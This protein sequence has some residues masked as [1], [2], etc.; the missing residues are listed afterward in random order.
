MFK[1]KLFLKAFSIILLLVSIFA[2]SMYVISLPLINR[3]VGEIE[4]NSAKTILENVYNLVE[5]VSLDLESEEKAL[6]ESRKRELRN[7]VELGISYIGNIENQ[8]KTG[9]LS[10]DDA[11]KNILEN[12]RWF[13]YGNNDYLWISDYN[14][15]LI[16]HPD[17]KLHNTD[18]SKIKDIYGIFIVPPM[19]EGARKHGEVYHYYYWRRLGES[20]PVKKM[21]YATHLKDW[22]WVIG[23]G[24]YIDDI[25]NDLQK[26]KTNEVDNL[27]KQLA[28]IRIAK[29]GY[30]Y[31]FTSDKFLVSHPNKNIDGT[32]VSYLQNPDTKRPILDELKEIADKTDSYLYYRWDKPEH[33]SEYKYYKKSWVRYFKKFDWYIASSVYEDELK[34]GSVNLINS[35]GVIFIVFI[36]LSLI[37][38]LI[39]VNNLIKPI[40]ELSDTAEKVKYGDLTVRSSVKGN[41]ELGMLARSFNGMVD[42][43]QKNIVNL[44]IMVTERTKELETAYNEL[45]QLDAMKSSFLSTVSHELR[46]PLTSVMGFAKIIKKRLND[47]VFPA[48]TQKTEKIEKTV[49]QIGEN[50]D[51]IVF[52]SERL[53]VLINDILDLAKMESGKMEWKMEKLEINPIIDHAVA[54]TMSLFENRNVKLVKVLADDLPTVT[55][56]RDRLIQVVIN[57]ISNAVKFTEAGDVTVK[58]QITDDRRFVKVSVNDTGIGIA[59]T[60]QEVVFD[61]FKQI[62]SD[63]LVKKPKGTGLGLSICKQIVTHHKGDIWVESVPGKGSSFIFTLPIAF[64]PDN[65]AGL[66]ENSDVAM[67]KELN[68]K[69]DDLKTKMATVMSSFENSKRNILV[70]DDE[71]AMRNLIRQ[72]L[73]EKE[74]TVFEA[75][76]G[77]EAIEQ[78]MKCRPGLVILDIKMPGINGFDVAVTLK[79]D[80]ETMG[81]PVIILSIIE[82]KEKGYRIGV[83]KYLTKPLNTND[84]IKE[85]ELLLTRGVAAKKIMVVSEDS[86]VT[87]NITDIFGAQ[88][89]T[90]LSST[91]VDECLDKTKKEKPGMIIIESTFPKRE[92]LIQTVRFTKEL[93]NT[94]FV[95]I[96]K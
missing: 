7:I 45:K 63:T 18:F 78:I 37:L 57:L 66:S 87:A 58:S 76:N 11:R 10:R 38:G 61:K 4:E 55:A 60:D 82:D 28:K 25:E 16:S 84:L 74:Y 48:I 79:K 24:V 93:D 13:K 26:K 3:K 89:Y 23:T 1:S 68:I 20:K 30:I 53:T 91:T 64:Q 51:I 8:V 65:I 70:V 80:P 96:T 86:E 88:G 56:D 15:V 35:I 39:F 47:I 77:E 12:M 81:I 59:K 31:I 49:R 19:V 50:V 9:K 22:N 44:D 94:Y 14:S 85:V 6:M 34:Q 42:N 52:E 75:S 71:A 67:K 92:N 72:M 5:K 83:D 2:Y 17:P 41:D 21:S 90:V 27:R 54:A 40:R 32:N 62:S 46:T 29:T 95:I 33:P 73:E 36:A 43:L 69:F